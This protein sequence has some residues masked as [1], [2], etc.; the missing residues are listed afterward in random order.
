MLTKLPHSRCS[1]GYST[2]WRRPQ[3]SRLPRTL[4]RSFPAESAR[5]CHRTRLRMLDIRRRNLIPSWLPG[6]LFE[7]KCWAILF[8][9]SFIGSNELIPLLVFYSSMKKIYNKELIPCVLFYFSDFEHSHHSWH[10]IYI[11][12]MIKRIM[13]YCLYINSYIKHLQKVVQNTLV[14]VFLFFLF[15]SR[16]DNDHLLYSSCSKFYRLGF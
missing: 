6:G 5:P 3:R 4:R 15:Q 14:T 16:T 1:A 12:Y 8:Y 7:I 10:N 2:R 13:Q 11:L 9:V